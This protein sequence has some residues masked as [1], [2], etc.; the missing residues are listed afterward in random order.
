[1][2]Q[3]DKLKLR[4][5]NPPIT[6]VQEYQEYRLRGGTIGAAPGSAAAGASSNDP[7]GLRTP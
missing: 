1:M 5:L 3:V 2:G 7:L 6:T 4:K